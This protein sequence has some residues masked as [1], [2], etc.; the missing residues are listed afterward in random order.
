MIFA[1]RYLC[2]LFLRGLGS[3]GTFHESLYEAAHH[4]ALHTPGSD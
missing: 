1:S 3:K 2:G 4:T